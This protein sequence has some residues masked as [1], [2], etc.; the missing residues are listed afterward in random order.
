MGSYLSERDS[1]LAQTPPTTG[2]LNDGFEE[3]DKSY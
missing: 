1:S 2:A 3:G